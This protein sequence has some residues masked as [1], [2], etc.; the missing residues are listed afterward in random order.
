M[1]D[2]DL[3]DVWYHGASCYEGGVVVTSSQPRV[4]LKAVVCG[5]QRVVK[6]FLKE[7]ESDRKVGMTP[8]GDGGNYE[9][10]LKELPWLVHLEPKLGFF[11]KPAAA[12]SSTTHAQPEGPD[13]LE[14]PDESEMF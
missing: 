7:D 12:S 6:E 2:V 9:A 10:L 13:E 11:S 8:K 5:D 14:A 3:A 1:E 4:P